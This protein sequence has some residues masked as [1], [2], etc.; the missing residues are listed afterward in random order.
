M[1]RR[2]DPEIWIDPK[3]FRPERWLENPDAPI[4][5]FGVGSRMCI[6]TQ[7]A[8]RE[9]YLLFLRLLN[10][11]EV[12]PAG[13]VDHHP[14]HGVRDVTALT[15]LPKPYKVKFVPREL[16]ILKTALTSAETH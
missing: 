12:L 10:A 11:F 15:T 1:V 3:T 2:L 9:L 5:T 14:V 8:F 7:M 6:G 4:F 13:D 16:E